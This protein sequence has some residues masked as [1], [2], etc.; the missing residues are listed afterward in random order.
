MD[1]KPR[2]DKYYGSHEHLTREDEV[3][4]SSN[5]S[6]GLVF[7]A[8]CLVVGALSW[9]SDHAL[10][11]YWFTAAAGFLVVALARPRLLG[12]FNRLWTKFGLLLGAIVAPIMLALIFYVFVTPIGLLMRATGKDPLRLKFDHA[13]TSYWIDRD[14]VADAKTSFKNQY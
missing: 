8:V 3:K 13:A 1:K 2:Q 9:W 11:P 14:K 6:F 7:A 10:W 12:P 4:S 5:R